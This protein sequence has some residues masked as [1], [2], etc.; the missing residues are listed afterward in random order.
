[1]KKIGILII[2]AIVV[3]GMIPAL[4]SAES[5]ENGMNSHLRPWG[6][7]NYTSGNVQGKFVSFKINN[8]GEIQNFE[9]KN[10]TVFKS[11]TYENET[12]GK[13]R[14]RGA[15]LF[16]FGIGTN[17]NWSHINPNMKAMW[18]FVHAHDGP[19]AALHVV[20]YGKDTVKLNIADGENIT[21]ISNHTIR[22]G[23][24]IRGI[25][26]FSGSAS[27]NGNTVSIKLGAKFIKIGNH[28]YHGGSLVFVRT[29]AWHM[30]KRVAE[31]I[32]HAIGE[33]KVAGEITVGKHVDFE[34]YT[35]GFHANV[36][37][38]KH[39]YVSIDVDSENHE[40]KVVLININKTDMQYDSSHHLTVKID[41]K[42]IKETNDED[43]LAGGTQGKYTVVDNG[44]YLTVLV[45]M[46]HFSEHSI[47]VESQPNNVPAE[48]MGNPMY[49]GAIIAIIVVAI[50][51]VVALK[52]KR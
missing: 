35:Y 43:V 5:H 24:K 45:Y 48:I 28:T 31:R 2:S 50:V 49:M 38:M 41:G 36:G 4:A 25:I 17:M 51:I 34:N 37:T 27:V 42:E 15:N 10:N 44:D 14:V 8:N 7:F 12:F 16:Y 52:K 29:G 20:I 26:A 23:G 11:I 21:H 6:H 18:R 13:V 3:F 40:G 46:P 30:P 33:G 9:I 19:A 22:I 1:M 47:D 39:N 32:I